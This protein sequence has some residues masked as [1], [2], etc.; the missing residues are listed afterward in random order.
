[1][2][3]KQI[4]FF[5]VFL[6]QVIVTEAFTFVFSTMEVFHKGAHGGVHGECMVGAWWGAW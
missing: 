3:E 5:V 6:S 1:M 4:R 2:G